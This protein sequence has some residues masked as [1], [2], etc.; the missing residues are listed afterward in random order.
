M[1]CPWALLPTSRPPCCCFP[2]LLLLWPRAA[3]GS[4]TLWD[5]DSLAPVFKM[6]LSKRP[7]STAFYASNKIYLATDT[8]VRGLAAC[9]GTRGRSAAQAPPACFLLSPR[10]DCVPH[11]SVI[12][13]VRHAVT[14]VKL[15][16]VR[17]LFESWMECNS[18]VTSL[19]PVTP[20]LILAEF[21]DSSIRLVGGIVASPTVQVSIS[22]Y[23]QHKEGRGTIV[24]W[25]YG[26]W[27]S[28]GTTARCCP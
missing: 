25:P 8:E 23:Y 6:K 3:P 11:Q 4:V 5:L 7:I 14:Q 9:A 27:A 1:S 20:G 18:P 12:V 26:M 21:Q 10:P 19:R 24:H 16:S 13:C 22:S 17:H 28:H 2:H 15:F